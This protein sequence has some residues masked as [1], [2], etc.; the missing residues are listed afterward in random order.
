M[1]MKIE[2]MSRM[3]VELLSTMQLH[4]ASYDV[5]SFSSAINAAAN[6]ENANVW[7]AAAEMLRWMS[8]IA[9]LWRFVFE[10]LW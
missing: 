7:I 6:S 3:A 2:A 5:I 9:L 10:F 8:F 1:T 4:G